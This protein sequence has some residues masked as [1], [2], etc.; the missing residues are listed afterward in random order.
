MDRAY[1]LAD[2]RPACETIYPAATRHRERLDI[3]INR[4]PLALAIAERRPEDQAQRPVTD[5]DIRAHLAGRWSRSQPK[6][7]ALDY[8]TDGA[9]RDQR[10]KVRH[11][12][13]DRKGRDG[14]PAVDSLG[15][16]AND[17]ALTRIAGE[18]RRT[19]FGWR[20]GQAVAAF[21]DGRREVMAAYD[22]LRER[23]RAEGDSVALGR[24]FRETLTRHGVLLKQAKPSAPARRISPPC[25]T[26]VAASVARSSMP[27][28]NSIPAQAAT[29]VRPPCG[30][31]IGS[32]ARRNWCQHSNPSRSL[33]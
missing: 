24:A 11:T 27:S 3:Y 33:A 10:E 25:S 12:G 30:M 20:H 19:A 16:A 31:C 32:S 8:I 18:I 29:G 21:A 14:V 2:D 22:G 28:R 23:T 9:W 17:N 1:L 4:A 15:T 7:A 13:G 6:E 26:N 5:T